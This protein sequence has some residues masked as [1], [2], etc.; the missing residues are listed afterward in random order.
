MADRYRTAGCDPTAEVTDF[1][2]QPL[3]PPLTHD[4]GARSRVANPTTFEAA[5]TARWGNS[6][7]G[8]LPTGANGPDANLRP[9]F[10]VRVW[11]KETQ[12]TLHKTGEARQGKA[13]IGGA[14]RGEAR[15]GKARQARQ[16]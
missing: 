7:V 4:F 8:G 12:E 11:P 16:Q 5:T 6:C 14:R 15:K 1:C 13:G 10:S 2:R 9:P 3:G